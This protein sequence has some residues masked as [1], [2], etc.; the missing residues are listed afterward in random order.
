MPQDE[1]ADLL[2]DIMRRERDEKLDALRDVHPKANQ[3]MDALINMYSSPD[4]VDMDSVDRAATLI[5]E[6]IVAGYESSARNEAMGGRGF[7]PWDTMQ[8]NGHGQMLDGR[9]EPIARFDPRALQQGALAPINP[10]GAYEVP[11]VRES[12]VPIRFSPEEQGHDGHGLTTSPQRN[13]SIE[14]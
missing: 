8:F 7:D 1:I 12:V 13:N 2:N 6:N 5:M 9:G 4:G 11:E 3:M 14:I 10:L